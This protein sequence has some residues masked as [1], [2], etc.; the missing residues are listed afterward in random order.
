MLGLFHFHSC[1][2]SK[3]PS[4]S[5]GAKS[6]PSYWHKVGK[7]VEMHDSMPLGCFN[8]ISQNTMQ[9]KKFL[10][11]CGIRSFCG[12][13]SDLECTQNFPI[14]F[15][16]IAPNVSFLTQSLVKIGTASCLFSTYY[17]WNIDLNSSPS[18]ILILCEIIVLRKLFFEILA[19]LL[20]TTYFPWT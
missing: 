13:T 11:P 4:T 14:L 18:L 6:L 1:K 8:M 5:S 17:P 12:V 2:F 16:S 10:I 15:T 19:A 3:A 7:Q 20:A 9:N